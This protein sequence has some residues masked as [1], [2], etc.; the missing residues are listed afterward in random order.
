MILQNKVVIITGASRGIGRAL[1]LAFASE[2]A[3]LILAARTMRPGTGEREGSIDEV[4]AHIHRNGGNAL[5]VE[6]DVGNEEQVQHLV[7]R[8]LTE[9]GPIDIL[10]NNAASGI[11]KPLLEQS[12]K[13]WDW[14]L[15]INTRAP[16]LCVKNAI[17]IMESG[18]AII[19]ITS[20][21]SSK[22]LPYY[23]TVGISKAGI[24]S[25]TR[26]MA[27]ELASKGISVNAVSP[28]YI[29]TRALR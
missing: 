28:G 29:D 4:V 15:N 16:W 24:E 23:S 10:I 1:A 21:G 14:T 20:L 3:K 17:P 25:L 6:C 5:G 13:D 22:V 2:G 12:E 18:G 9:V 19:N 8:T 7:G 11:Q 27:I 26:Y